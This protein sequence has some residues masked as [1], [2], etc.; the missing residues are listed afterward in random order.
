MSD[1]YLGIIRAATPETLEIQQR[2]IQSAIDL[3]T[4]AFINIYSIPFHEAVNKI[5]A[6]IREESI[7]RVVISN[8]PF[9]A[10]TIAQ[11]LIFLNA[12]SD[13]GADAFVVG[14][15]RKLI[16]V[17]QKFVGLLES[18]TRKNIVNIFS[19]DNLEFIIDFLES[20]ITMDTAICH[21]TLLSDELLN[22][23][24]DEIDP[25]VSSDEIERAIVLL[26]LLDTTDQSSAPMSPGSN[27]YLN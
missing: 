16:P 27:I 25:G 7:R 1:T 26:Q 15:E 9:V 3:A 12:I 6:A 4:V 2:A 19:T 21:L 22:F 23:Q 11:M 24:T 18:L 5:R 13:A 8:L 10:P 17:N 20:P 14:C